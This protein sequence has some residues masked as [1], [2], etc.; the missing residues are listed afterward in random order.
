M[1]SIS[2]K[3]NEKDEL[4]NQ[5]LECLKSERCNKYDSWLKIGA[6]IYNE[7]G[8]FILFNEWSKK[9]PEKYSLEGCRKAWKSF[10]ENKEK[11]VTI[12]SLMKWAKEDNLEKFEEIEL[13]KEL[14]IN[15]VINNILDHGI[16]DTKVAKL[17]SLVCN[18]KFLW[19][20]INEHWYFINKFNIWKQDKK[21]FKNYV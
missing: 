2:E 3:S 17:Y 12:K 8:S 13:P 14:Y 5:Y 4:L 19:D 18:H 11:K 7:Q 21:R 1:T 15:N 6:I 20:E 10:N 16:S 9:C